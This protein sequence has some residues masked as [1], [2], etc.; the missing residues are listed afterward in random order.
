MNVYETITQQIIDQLEQGTVPW[1]RPWH[2]RSVP[3]NLFSLKPYRGINVWL[4]LS[5]PY[6]S[7]YWLT[8][9][10]ANEIGGM[11]NKGEKGT[12]V[13]FWKFPNN[14]NAE[15]VDTQIDRTHAAPFVRTYTVFN[16]EQCS[17]PQSL[18]VR[19]ATPAPHL[20]A[21]IT[22]CENIIANMSQRPTIEHGGDCAYYLPTLDTV[23]VPRRSQFVS[24]SHYFAKLFHEAVHSTGHGSRLARP[25]VVDPVSFAS[26]A[27]CKEELIAEFG[28]AFLCGICGIAPETLDNATAYIAHWIEKLQK[29]KALVIQA[30]SQ[31]Q[32]AVDFIVGKIQLNDVDE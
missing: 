15:D 18:T 21:P 25:G 23:T 12:T 3:R 29:D 28:A 4:L 30:A 1:R 9:H 11:V 13:V 14:R 8:F 16:T 5:R 31:A 2:A 26:H 22:K 32:R 10:Q 19:L 27:Y 6:A 17:L 20:I 24:M 7:P